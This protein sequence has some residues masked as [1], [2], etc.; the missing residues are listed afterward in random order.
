MATMYRVRAR[1]DY[2]TGAP[3]LSTFYFLSTGGSPNATD[4]ATVAGRVRG[5]FDVAKT[6]LTTTT[7][8][9]VSPQVDL[10]AD[11]SG[12]LLGGFSITPP[13][14]V[15]GTVAG[16]TGPTSAMVGIKLLTN[17]IVN[18]R[19]VQGRSFFGPIA[20]TLTNFPTPQA[21]VGT[22]IS[23]F[24]TALITASPPAAVAPL[25]VWSRPKVSPALFG[26]FHQVTAAVGAPG[27][28][29]LRSRRD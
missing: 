8:V 15:T 11:T 10:I 5:A 29:V 20:G 9:T 24:I 23:A 2:G 22:A 4:A 6:I 19:R 14:G 26:S 3:G 13:A 17:D 12:D 27:F 1:W 18:N 28:F 25:V 21:G 7:N 16:P